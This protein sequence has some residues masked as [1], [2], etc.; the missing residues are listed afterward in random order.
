MG[1][2]NSHRPRVGRGQS[3]THSGPA[4]A[5]ASPAGRGHSPDVGPEGHRLRAATGQAKAP[6]LRQA[7]L[8]VCVTGDSPQKAPP[9][10]GSMIRT[11][12]FRRC[13]TPSLLTPRGQAARQRGDSLRRHLTRAGAGGEAGG[14]GLGLALL[15]LR[16]GGRP[17]GPPA[18]LGGRRRG[19]GLRTPRLGGL[20]LQGAP[21]LLGQGQR[22]VVASPQVLQAA[23][24]GRQEVGDGQRQEV[25]RVDAELEQRGGKAGRGPSLPPLPLRPGR[26]ARLRWAPRS[27]ARAAGLLAPPRTQRPARPL[28]A[29]PPSAPCT[30]WGARPRG[31]RCSQTS[32]WAAGLCQG[33]PGGRWSYTAVSRRD[34]CS[35]CG[36]SPLVPRPARGT[37]RL[38]SLR[39]L[40]ARPGS[41]AAP[42]PLQHLHPGRS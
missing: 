26:P 12:E 17:C 20:L 3:L 31:A 42:S 13:W 24:H 33:P 36:R 22:L 39:W 9:V 2:W 8:E 16:P 27:E 23:Q 29:R 32:V 34:A 41:S 25:R 21:Q 11:T 5:R 37:G 30:A 7:A 18:V 10:T 6:W 4:A 14:S 40:W 38:G 1:A 19:S 35:A 28:P 15:A